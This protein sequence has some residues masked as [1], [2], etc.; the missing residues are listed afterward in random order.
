MLQR[1]RIHRQILSLSLLRCQ[2]CYSTRQLATLSTRPTQDMPTFQYQESSIFQPSIRKNPFTPNPSSINI[3]DIPKDITP[4][5]LLNMSIE[6]LQGLTHEEFDYLN[7]IPYGTVHEINEISLKIASIIKNN[8]LSDPKKASQMYLIITNKLLKEKIQ[9]SVYNHFKKREVEVSVWMLISKPRSQKTRQI[10]RSNIESILE[11][12]INDKSNT[13]LHYLSK[14]ASTDIIN[15]IPI[16]LNHHLF[17]KL[18]NSVSEKHHGLLYLY[19]FQ[20]NIQSQYKFLMDKW[21]RKLLTSSSLI[22]QYIVQ[23]GYSPPIKYEN[24]PKFEITNLQKSKMIQFLNISDFE[25]FINKGIESNQPLKSIYYLNCMLEKFEKKCMISNNRIIG[26]SNIKQDVETLLKCLINII[27]KF[28]GGYYCIDILKYMANEG[29]KPGF[30]VYHLLLKNLRELGNFNEFVVVLNHMKLDNLSEKQKEIFSNEILSLMEARFPN[31][32]KVIIGYVGAIYG[33]QGLGIL[34]KLKILSIPYGSGGI[35]EIPS[36]DIVQIATVDDRLKGL[37]LNYKSLA[38]IYQVLLSSIPDV[39]KSPNIILK[40]YQEYQSY[41]TASQSSSSSSSTTSSSSTKHREQDSVITV[42]LNHLLRT[43][44]PLTPEHLPITSSFENYEIAKYITNTYYTSITP[45]LNTISSTNIE[46]LIQTALLKHQDYQFAIKI[47]QISRRF[48]RPFTFNQIY[49]F[50]KYHYD[51]KNYQ[52]AKLWYD[53]LINSGAISTGYM[54]S[55]LLRIARKLNW[56]NIEL[57][58]KM[59]LGMNQ[60]LNKMALHKLQLNPL[61]MN[62]L[63]TTNTTSITEDDEIIEDIISDGNEDDVD[64]HL[65]NKDFGNELASVLCKF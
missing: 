65:M 53:E 44:E 48:K 21:K 50:I 15:A 14:L 28:K 36:V 64:D 3:L 16:L 57:K 8:L 24:L 13:I 55:D 32:P 59:N 6:Q 31:S 41:I 20:I 33:K 5:P 30:E 34:N 42:F 63:S 38:H 23:T 35:N 17:D 45:K 40:L 56:N 37:T 47:L 49:P 60:K 25:N 46:L 22:N 52:D 54:I 39:S 51:N 18:I 11:S 62:P 58:F 7:S 61:L 9:K 10:I 29:L 26:D 4:N 19:M 43:N 27:M 12:D 2:G 1:Y